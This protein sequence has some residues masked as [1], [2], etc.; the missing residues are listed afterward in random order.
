M[1]PPV[2][3]AVPAPFGFVTDTLA[4]PAVPA[5][6]MAVMELAVKAETVAAVFPITTEAPAAKFDPSILI[7]VPPEVGPEFG[8]MEVI[9]GGE[10]SGVDEGV[11]VK[12]FVAVDPVATVTVLETE[13]Y[14][15]AETLI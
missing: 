1:N 5:G 14:P 15:L 7:V 8:E 4:E 3:V 2:R 13:L 11:N 12:F 6:V 9:E 10:E